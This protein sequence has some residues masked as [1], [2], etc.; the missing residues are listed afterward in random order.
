MTKYNMNKIQSI[1]AVIIGIVISIGVLLYQGIT[2]A[3]NN[4]MIIVT[5]REP[6]DN[7]E[8]PNNNVWLGDDGIPK[9]EPLTDEEKNRA[10]D[11]IK[12]DESLKPILETNEW[13]LNSIMGRYEEDGTKIGADIHIIFK[14]PVWFDKSYVDAF[15]FKERHATMWMSSL[16]ITVD[17]NKNK[18]IGI[19]PGMAKLPGDTPSSVIPKEAESIAREYASNRLGN[20]IDIRLHTLMKAPEFPEGIA[21][22]M[23]IKD[24]QP[25]MFVAIN[26]ADMSIDEEH[27]GVVGGV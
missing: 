12:Q 21:T 8:L 4:S 24:N 11:I 26:L 27:T 18:V 2:T 19:G 16:T 14:E 22:F 5:D 25:K 10:M 20:D 7:R 17:L 13:Y 23:V 3:S 6:L 15:T 1:I 9:I